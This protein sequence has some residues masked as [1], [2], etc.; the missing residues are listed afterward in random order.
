[1][2]CPPAV[3]DP[4]GNCANRLQWNTSKLPTGT[5]WIAAVDDDPP[6]LTVNYGSGPV[7]VAHGAEAATP[8]AL[9]VRPDGIGS[10]NG[11]YGLAWLAVGTPPLTFDLSYGTEEPD[12][13]QIA[14]V[15]A[16]AAPATLDGDGHTWRYLWNLEG[17]PD[18][19][20]FVRL[21]VTDGNGASS[22]LD[23][24]YAINIYHATSP[25]PD[26]AAMPPPTPP[27]SQGSG[28]AIASHTDDGGL[29]TALLALAC[30]VYLARGRRGGGRLRGSG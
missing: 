7:R 16:A 22:T 15:I 28:C 26:M 3:R 4:A 29:T 10:W 14:G 8:A 11:S 1:V 24:L 23:S 25:P 19:S 30:A 5:Y 6:T 17:L 27:P 21:K 12:P 2:V 18:A 20:Y 13:L 9:F